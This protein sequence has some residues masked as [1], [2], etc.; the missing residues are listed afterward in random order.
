VIQFLIGVSLA[1]VIAVAGYWRKALSRSGALAATFVGSLV[2]GF[3]GLG[4]GVL[5]VAFFV[6][7]SL[8]SLY[9][10]ARK[11][12]IAEK[13]EK[14]SRRDAVQVL[15]NGG[16][17]T[18]LA[19]L[20]WWRPATWIFPA[21]VGAVAAATA[22]TWATELGILSPVPPRLI[23]TGE[24]VPPGTNGAISRL[25]TLATIT[26]AL[27]IGFVAAATAVAGYAGPRYE[28]APTWLTLFGGAGGVAGSLFD[29][30]LGATVQR[31]Q[32]CPR[33]E[34]ETEGQIHRCGTATSYLRGWPWLDNDW[35]N[36]LATVAGSLVAAGLATALR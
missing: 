28:L 17:L 23:T 3:G 34:E 29:S 18:L 15:A 2:F 16:W 30:L 19:L 10:P 31:V 20:A 11:A 14:G 7:S 26:G 8:F 12:E 21:A 24:Q 35:V 22:D 36:F 4:W 33:C 5:L 1:L 9:S 13:F 25:G 6:S 27:F 32:Y